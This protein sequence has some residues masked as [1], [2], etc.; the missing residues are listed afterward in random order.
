MQINRKEL[1][2]SVVQKNERKSEQN[3]I[4][5]PILTLFISLELRLKKRTQKEDKK[6]K[7]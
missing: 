7:R 2:K 3:Q 6:W 4:Y 1:G 5:L